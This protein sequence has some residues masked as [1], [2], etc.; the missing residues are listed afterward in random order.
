[1]GMNHKL[2]YNVLQEEEEAQSRG[3]RG[4]SGGQRGG[5]VLHC[6]KEDYVQGSY[7]EDQEEE[8]ERDTHPPTSSEGQGPRLCQQRVTLEVDGDLMIVHS[9]YD[10]GSTITL[11]RSDTAQEAGLLPVLVPRWIARGLQEGDNNQKL[12][13]TGHQVRP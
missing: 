10:W 9:L 7:E 11:V 8:P 2:L 12:L 4:G 6:I 5:G 3:D 13:S 1:M